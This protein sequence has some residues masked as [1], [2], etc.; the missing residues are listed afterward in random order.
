[1]IYQ[2]AEHGTLDNG[3]LQ[4][5]VPAVTYGAANEGTVLQLSINVDPGRLHGTF[6]VNYYS[7]ES[8]NRLFFCARVDVDT[9][10][11]GWL[12]SDEFEWEVTPWSACRAGD[13]PYADGSAGERT[14][15]VRCSHPAVVRGA[16]RFSKGVRKAGDADAEIPEGACDG[17]P[18]PA[19]RESCP[20]P[21]CVGGPW[22][23]WAAGVSDG[24]S[25]ALPKGMTGEV[26]LDVD[27]PA[28]NALEIGST[29]RVGDVQR[30]LRLTADSV[31]VGDQGSL[32]AG[33]AESPYDG[34]FEVLLTSRWNPVVSRSVEDGV[35]GLGATVKSV[36]VYRGG[37]M[38]LYGREVT[39]W[40]RLA[41]HGLAGAQEVVVLD[42]SGW[43]VGD[44]LVIVNS[45]FYD[46]EGDDRDMNE[47]RRIERISDDGKR[48]RLDAPLRVSHYGAGGP[49]RIGDVDGRGGREVDM[50]AEVALLTR[51][52][53]IRGAD[54]DVDVGP[55][56][57]GGHVVMHQGAS[58]MGLRHVEV[59]PNMGQAG[60]LGRYPIHFHRVGR[61]N[62]QTTFVE[63]GSIHDTFQRSITVHDTQALSIKDTVTYNARGHAIFLEDGTEVDNAIVGNLVVATKPQVIQDVR[64]DFHDDLPSAFWITNFLNTLEG[65]VAA[66]T[67][68]GVGFWYKVNS[69]SDGELLS[70]PQAIAS[71][72]GSFS[73]NVAHSNQ[74]SG[75]WMWHDWLPCAQRVNSYKYVEDGP[76]R[77]T[78][79]GATSDQL[80]MGSDV[81][82]EDEEELG[83]FGIVPRNPQ[84]S[85]TCRSQPVQVLEGLLTYKHRD[86]GTAVYLSSTNIV[87]KDFTSVSDTSAMA[88]AQV[89]RDASGE[90]GFSEVDGQVIDGLLVAGSGAHDNTLNKAKWCAEMSRKRAPG[91]DPKACRSECHPWPDTDGHPSGFPEDADFVLARSEDRY[92]SGICL[93]NEG[94][95]GAQVTKNL[96]LVDFEP[97]ES[98][99]VVDTMGVHVKAGIGLEFPVGARRVDSVTVVEGGDDVTAETNLGRIVRLHAESNYGNHETVMIG[100]DALAASRK[101]FPDGAIAVV[102]AGNDDLF[103]EENGC[104]DERIYGDELSVDAVMCDLRRLWLTSFAVD[105][106][107]TPLMTSG[108]GPGELECTPSL[109]LVGFDEERTY[110]AVNNGP[111]GETGIGR[112]EEAADFYRYRYPFKAAVGKMYRL[113]FD[114]DEFEACAELYTKKVGK[115]GKRRPVYLTME[116]MAYDRR[117]MPPRAVELVLEFPAGEGLRPSVK[118]FEDKTGGDYGR[119]STGTEIYVPLASKAKLSYVGQGVTREQVCCDGMWYTHVV[120]GDRVGGKDTA[121]EINWVGED[122]A[123]DDCDEPCPGDAVPF[124]EDFEEREVGSPIP[125]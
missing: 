98:C 45:D 56:F 66:G 22:S 96:R 125:F 20:P 19:T 4:S 60:R 121:M 119:L 57:F 91:I 63:G 43:R 58:G 10:D 38:A 89:F 68:N 33:S 76:D 116:K 113:S 111:E 73:K 101:D 109:L 5:F 94:T 11:E 16:A 8:E 18:K 69:H 78:V 107:R 122:G 112:P 55:S 118:Y 75:F 1:M 102:P 65:N 31:L 104:V 82:T 9:E 44:E 62:G 83:M 99:G 64:E 74:F 6:P 54:E 42:G 36:H 40:T 23:S 110:A 35:H 21:S 2:E 115:G 87:W 72:V 105:F 90:G 67:T 29:L 47:R 77:Y 25:V 70:H 48:V 52:V 12:D 88:F 53:R 26:V 100:P 51:S 71:P 30:V 80:R 93:S 27:T 108:D 61:A 3:R 85:R 50:R 86:V 59:G 95:V 120:L 114:I 106:S 97:Q 37:R 7:L 15:E 39:S 41:E 34:S 123:D 117:T 81:E 79:F 32:L 28:L 103:F 14:R 49:A 84:W 24:D 92:L 46:V 124:T 13:C 17:K